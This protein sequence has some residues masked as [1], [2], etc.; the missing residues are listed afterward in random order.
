MAVRQGLD[1]CRSKRLREWIRTSLSIIIIIIILLLLLLLYGAGRSG[2]RIP[3]EA[4]FS[5][6]VQT[7]PGPHPAS[8]TM[9]AGSFLAIKAAGAWRWPPTPSSAEVKERVELYLHSPLGLRGLFK[10]ELCLY[11]L[12][13]LLLLL[14]FAIRTF[15]STVLTTTIFEVLSGDPQGRPWFPAV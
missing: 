12:L 7:G 6:P 15:E 5:A 13:L 14:H 11:L 10:G 2:D 8:D 1:S 9:G 3:V 4:R